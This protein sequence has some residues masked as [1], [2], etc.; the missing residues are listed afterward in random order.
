MKLMGGKIKKI[1]SK[2]SNGLAVFNTRSAAPALFRKR[3]GWLGAVLFCI[4]LGLLLPLHF[5]QAQGD[6]FSA[7][8]SI[9]VSIVNIVLQVVLAVSNLFMGLA[10]LILNWVLSPYFMSLPYTHGGIVDIGWPIVRDF[11]NLFFIVAL[12]FIGLATALRISEYQVKKALPR[13]I[14]IALLINFTPVISGLI[15]DAT[16]ILMNFFLEEVAGLKTMGVFFVQQGT[17]LHDIFSRHFFDIRYAAA[18]LGKTIAMIAFDWIGGLIFLMFALLFI[19]RYIMIWVLVIV[20]PIAFLSKVFPGAQQHVF[21]SILGWDEWWRQFI[22]WSMLGIVAG[23]FLY[24]AEQLIVLAPGMF[25]AAPPDLAFGWLTIPV[26]EFVNNLLPYGV[27]LAF[28][29]I[30]FFTATS[31]SAMG[32]GA[33]VNFA[34]TKGPALGK[35][36]L[37]GGLTPLRKEVLPRLEKGLRV[38]EAAGWT[39]GKLRRVPLV[40]HTGPVAAME[41]YG[42]WR[43]DINKA[44]EGASPYSSYSIG[45]RIR[46]GQVIGKQA[47]GEL[48]QIISRGDSEDYFKAMSRKYSKD[49]QKPLTDEELLQHKG[50]LKETKGLIKIAYRGGLGNDILRHDPRFAAVIAGEKGVGFNYSEKDPTIQKHLQKSLPLNIREKMAEGETLTSEEEK[51]KTRA[52]KSV[53]IMRATEETRPGHLAAAEREVFEN[54][55]VVSATAELKGSDFY[56][57]AIRQVKVFVPTYMDTMDKIFKEFVEQH[58]E[59]IGEVNQETATAFREKYKNYFESIKNNYLKAAGMTAPAGF[60]DFVEK[61][62]NKRGTSSILLE[63]KGV[64]PPDFRWEKRTGWAKVPEEE[65]EE[66]KRKKPWKEPPHF[67]WEEKAGWVEVPKEEK[68]RIREEAERKEIIKNW[69]TTEKEM[70]KELQKPIKEGEKLISEI[71]EQEKTINSLGAAIKEWGE[72]LASLRESLSGT[73]EQINSGRLSGDALTRANESLSRLNKEINEMEK[74]RGEMEI[75]KDKIEPAREAVEGMKIHLAELYKTA[76]EPFLEVEKERK[77]AEEK[78][79]EAKRKKKKFKKGK[80]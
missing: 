35:A 23:F 25:P 48:L 52:L 50:F 22:E 65:R 79:E 80:L 47:A 16:N 70:P 75:K 54:K 12:V 45:E 39:A 77:K 61:G 28:L 37:K 71:K 57:S 43:D 49:P 24:L 64:V 5:T 38:K 68:E 7:L 15:V 74:Q 1:F 31:T 2:E 33:V 13:L 9:P 60:D 44:K 59:K 21:R 41:K 46:S 19:L 18:T 14:I 69:P 56:R 78:I 11:A 76:I 10:G 29:L 67:R 36:A 66:I 72:H 32:A 40:R 51:I 3:A 6:F 8:L 34:K 42:E 73:E 17:M 58:G 63:G 62:E 53:S 20:S 4:L 30:G 55:D 26:V 27:V